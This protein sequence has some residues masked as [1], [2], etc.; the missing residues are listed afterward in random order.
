MSKLS[1]SLPLLETVELL[2]K[3]LPKTAFKAPLRDFIE[4]DNINNAQRYNFFSKKSTKVVNE[5]STLEPLL[6]HC[7]ARWLHVQYKLNY[8]PYYDLNVVCVY[9]DLNSGI[10]LAES[11]VNYFK[12]LASGD[13]YD[14][15]NYYLVP[16]YDTKV[17]SMA[18]LPADPKIQIM[19]KGLLSNHGSYQI[20][21]PVFVT[22][23]NDVL[24]YLSCDLVRYDSQV[25]KWLQA[26]IE[27]DIN[28]GFIKQEFREMDY[29]CHLTSKLVNTDQ[30]YQGHE[31][32]IPTRLINIFTQLHR[33]LPEH[34]LFMIDNPQRWTPSL[35]TMMKLIMGWN[36]HPVTQANISTQLYL[37]WSKST[38]ITRESSTFITDFIQVKKLY[39]EITEGSKTLELED[40]KDFASDWIDI[41]ESKE[42]LAC[43]ND[44]TI[45]ISRRNIENSKLAIIRG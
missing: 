25:K 12:K 42:I 37:P 18:R 45:N 32:Y 6:S 28:K 24:R 10:Q 14:R 11:V 36:S 34:K 29:W 4:W 40:L 43:G 2:Q 41:K 30:G 35:S 16:L 39:T 22:M 27:Y 8:Y 3:G 5:V 33:S 17:D 7:M 13:V 38:D 1:K 9:T 44:N 20:E 26:Y 21:D 19:D 23:V 15:L 31:R